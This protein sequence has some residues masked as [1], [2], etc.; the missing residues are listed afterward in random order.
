MS[1]LT[2]FDK[3]TRDYLKEIK[4]NEDVKSGVVMVP[5]ALTDAEL[6]KYVADRSGEVV[7]YKLSEVLK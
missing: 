2:F 5:T 3:E 7:T 4:Q 6:D 1:K